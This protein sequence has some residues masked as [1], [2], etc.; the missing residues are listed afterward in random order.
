MNLVFS[1]PVNTSSTTSSNGLYRL[2]IRRWVKTM[3]GHEEEVN[4]N[5]ITQESN[6]QKADGLRRCHFLLCNAVESF[7]Q[8]RP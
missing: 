7:L 4:Q 3:M 2:L 1:L 5:Y 8:F 6:L